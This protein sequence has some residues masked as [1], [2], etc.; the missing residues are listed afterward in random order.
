MFIV[1]FCVVFRGPY[2]YLHSL[3]ALPLTLQ[4]F[5]TYESSYV[6]C[7]GSYLY[8]TRQ[9]FTSATSTGESGVAEGY[10]PKLLYLNLQLNYR[11]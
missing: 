7:P 6:S 3:P 1:V 9:Y 8:S 2:S 11:K 4:D 10:V 5:F